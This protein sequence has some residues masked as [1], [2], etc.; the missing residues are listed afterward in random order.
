MIKFLDLNKQYHS[1]KSDIDSAISNVIQS[2]AFIG[3]KH[4]ENFEKNFSEFQEIKH[5]I[6]VGSGTNALE[7]AIWALGLEKGSEIIVPAN[8]YIATS[9]SV[10]HNGCKV[11]FA[12]VGDDYLINAETI[13][14]VLTANTKAIIPVHLYGQACDMDSILELSYK[15]NLKII[16]DCAQAHGAKYNGKKVGSF[17]DLAIFSFYPGKNL[18]AY[19][20]GGAVCTNSDIL[21][22]NIRLYANHG[23]K[24]KYHHEIEGVNSRLDGLQAAVLNVKLPHLSSWLEKRNSVASYYLENIDNNKIIL[25]KVHSNIYH[26]WHLFVVRVDKPQELMEYLNKNEIQSGI[27]YPIALPKLEAYNY[28]TQDTSDFFACISDVHLLSLP[29]G[30]HLEKFEIEKIVKTLN[31]F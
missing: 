10:T 31:E 30:E 16:E 6:G 27:H 28:I 29:M 3:G 21:A 20:D 1:I 7:L 8:S 14:E 9:E 2:T 22:Q 25:P 15:H 23:S 24:T 19:G 12:D 13:Q 18:G 5:T 4:V 11:V 17:G 26:S